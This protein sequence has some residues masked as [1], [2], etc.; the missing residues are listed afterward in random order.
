MIAGFN[1]FDQ[2]FR[3]L[4]RRAGNDPTRI[5]WLVRN[6]PE[7]LKLVGFLYFW[8]REFESKCAEH[9]FLSNVPRWF[10]DRYRTY[11]TRFGP[12]IQRVYGEL[13]L[14]A[15]IQDD[16]H[17]IPASVIL[18]PGRPSPPGKAP[19]GDVSGWFVPGEGAE[20]LDTVVHYLWQKYEDHGAD[21]PH[22][23]ERLRTGLDAWEWFTETVGIDLAAIERRWKTLPR[24]LIPS[25]VDPGSDAGA[26]QGLMA[27]LDDATRAYVFGLPAAAIAMCRAVCE[28][29]LREF[30]CPDRSQEDGLSTLIYLAEKQ[31]S[32]IR[33]LQLR[34]LVQRANQVMHNYPGGQVSEEEL[35]IARRFLETAKT[36]IESAPAPPGVN[37]RP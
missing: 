14:L 33:D 35:E 5:A 6:S 11:K 26:Q 34:G 3:Y 30:Y 16:V 4:E 37:A 27:L 36:L 24:T 15:L 18:S 29:V 31:H 20:A 10:I 19:P 2:R 23:A 17:G 9:R 8:E 1:E 21:D 22:L 13:W 7:V 25:R 32:R 28:R 12:E